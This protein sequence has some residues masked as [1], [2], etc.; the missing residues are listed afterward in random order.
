MTPDPEV[1][2]VPVAHLPVIRALIDQL[3]IHAIVDAALPRHPLSR[4]SDADC[5]VTMMLNILCGRVALFRMDGW[6]E[7]TDVELLLGPGR[8]SDALVDDRLASALD[9][10]DAHGTDNLLT[11][12][13]TSYLDRPA[14]ETT[15]SVH[16]DFTSV[17]FY[18]EYNDV[19]PN[20]SCSASASTGAPGSHLSAP[21]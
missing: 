8:D 19:S 9:H 14:R 6:L 11:A 4:V 10:I 16:Q 13:V 5:V 17:S 7:R 1:H 2:S 21:R 15:Y 12:V 18:G 20:N 3:G